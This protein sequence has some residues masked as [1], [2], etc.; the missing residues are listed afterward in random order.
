LGRFRIKWGEVEIEY[1]GEDSSEKYVTAW[2]KVDSIASGVPPQVIHQV[3]TLGKI[4]TVPREKQVTLPA[5]GKIGVIEFS[6][7][8]LKFPHNSYGLNI[9]EAIGLLL[10][11]YGGT[12]KPT[13]IA[14]LLR[15]GWRKV[16]DNA[17]RSYLT[18][19]HSKLSKYV[20][21]E[22]EGNRLTEEGINWIKSEVLPKLKVLK[23]KTA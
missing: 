16:K 5:K 7:D 18:A 20:I 22:D 6:G 13:Q 8:S 12:L 2:E 15:T 14:G 3:S 11:E 17:I 4:P 9:G 19:K 10:G 23:G 1:E 21:K